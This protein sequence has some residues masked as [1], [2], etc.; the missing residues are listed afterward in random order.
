MLVGEAGSLPLS[1]APEK[2]FTQVDSW[3]TYKHK[4][5]LVM[6]ARD[7]HSSLLQTFIN[8]RRTKFYNIGPW[9]QCYET[10]FHT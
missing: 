8:Y 1:G 6:L 7:K 10:F 4:T 2:S 5:R 3:L 9:A